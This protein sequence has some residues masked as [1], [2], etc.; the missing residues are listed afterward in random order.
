MRTLATSAATALS[1]K[2]TRGSTRASSSPPVR[3]RSERLRMLPDRLAVTASS[4]IP[5]TSARTSASL[6]ESVKSF[7]PWVTAMGRS[8]GLAISRSSA[9]RAC[10]AVM[11]P[12][13]MA[14][15]VTPLAISSSLEES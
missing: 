12:T 6:A 8:S 3:S 4:T 10:A 14:P 13:S 5:P 2:V 11:P 9:V 15:T 7:L 1:E